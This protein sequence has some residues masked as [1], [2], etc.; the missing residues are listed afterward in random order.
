MV[1]PRLRQPCPTL[2]I[3]IVAERL[4]LGGLDGG[5]SPIYYEDVDYCMRLREAG[6]RV[7]FEPTAVIDH[8]ESASE[9]NSI[10]RVLRNRKRFRSRHAIEMRRRQLPASETNVLAARDQQR[11]HAEVPEIGKRPD[12]CATP[13]RTVSLSSAPAMS[14][15]LL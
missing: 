10:A 6:Y 13:A 7:V 2:L 12:R 14:S 11:R 4:L 9:A 3:R 1:G 5:Y 15:M 8:F